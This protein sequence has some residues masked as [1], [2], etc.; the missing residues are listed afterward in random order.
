[1]KKDA[2]LKTNDLNNLVFKDGNDEFDHKTKGVFS[3]ITVDELQQLR[4][5]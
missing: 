1:M 5:E 4:K 3:K 2:N